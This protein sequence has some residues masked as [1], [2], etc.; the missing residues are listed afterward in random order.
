VNPVRTNLTTFCFTAGFLLAFAADAVGQNAAAVP[1][2][3]QERVA[4]ATWQPVRQEP[5]TDSPAED[6]KV[7]TVGHSEG[8]LPA[9]RQ[10]N[11]ASVISSPPTP[12]P[13]D[14]QIMSRD[15]VYESMGAPV[16]E[17]GEVIYDGAIYGGGFG[18]TACDAMA[19]PGC[20][21]DAAVC[22]GNCGGCDSMGSCC[23]GTCGGTNCTMCG[24]LYSGNAWRPAI[25]IRLPQ[26]GW[27]SYEYLHWWQDSMS[28]PPLVTSSTGTA[29]PRA[30]A[31]V[32]G[33]P[34]TRTLFGGDVLDGAF[35]GARIRFGIWLDNCHTWGLGGEYFSIG[36]E[37]ESF[38]ST[39]SGDPI[40]ARP[41]F[42]TQTG[43]E[44]AE[45]VAYP[46]VVS[47][48]VSARATSELVG[49]GFHLRNLRNCNEGCSG[50]IL[51][52]LMCGCSSPYCSRTELHVGYRYLQL[53]ESVTITE[54]LTGTNPSGNFDLTD[55]FDTRNQFNGFDLGWNYRR[56]RNYWTF[57][58]LG[59]LAI[60]NTRQTVTIN[61]QTSI[62]GAAPLPGGLLAQT[63]NIGQYK[64]DKFA[65][66]PE[67]NATLGYQLTDQFRL[68]A[69]Y[70]AIYWSN[71]VR[72]GDHISLDLNPNLLPPPTDPFSGSQRPAFAFDNTDY[73]VQGFN[74]GGEFR[75]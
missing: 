5:A 71:V 56:V 54:R 4:R 3:R 64:R 27:F 60:G 18:A 9:P 49:G 20:G 53:D 70:T 22:L 17:D 72:P 34:N 75:W 36:S 41:F 37:T 52:G 48:N 11:G 23:S 25:T 7:R 32:L 10:P 59:K 63:S 42:N 35:D 31:G 6:S 38:S 16:Y 68:M 69:G 61:G 13:L 74:V 65:V 39:S 8:T 67:L 33:R 50:G 24:E 26:D 30:D 45:L 62:D 29:T 51:C 43:V 40:L 15:V 47:G 28:L 57:D 55:Q 73:W 58:L 14:G 1:V 44:D 19:G 21:C 2:S 46:G 66:V 12:I